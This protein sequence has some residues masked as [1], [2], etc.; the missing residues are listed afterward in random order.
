MMGT[1]LEEPPLRRARRNEARPGEATEIHTRILR[2]SLG[3]EDSRAYWENV[4]L[5]V[6]QAE[7]G[8]IAFEQR[9][10]GGKSLERVRFLLSGFLAHFLSNAKMRF[11]SFF[12]L[13][14]IQPLLFASS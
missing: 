14:T 7:R 8:L 4:D 5:S 3:V 2:L 13:M 11:Q 10:F 6:P 9:W 1:S 12:M